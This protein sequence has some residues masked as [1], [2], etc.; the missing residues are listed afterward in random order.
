MERELQWGFQAAVNRRNKT[1]FVALP[2][3]AARA[4]RSRS[5]SGD[6]RLVCLRLEWSGPADGEPHCAFV[7]WNGAISGQSGGAATYLCSSSGNNRRGR[8][9]DSSSSSSSSSR[10]SSSSGRD[11]GDAV[12]P[13]DE[14]IEIPYALAHTLGLNRAV[15]SPSNSAAWGGENSSVAAALT[16]RLPVSCR[17]VPSPKAAQ[18]VEVAPC[19]VDDW[20]VIEARAALLEETLL[21]QVQVV[22]VGQTVP[23]WLSASDGRPGPATGFLL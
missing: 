23:F 12:L 4:I 14:A 10:S 15:V 9:R 20:E 5:G 18:R 22:F 11:G 6:Q 16:Q 13:D 2:S 17:V 8:G 19:S 3:R 21:A 1:C 7:G